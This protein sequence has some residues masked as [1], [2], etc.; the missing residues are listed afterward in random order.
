LSRVS[1]FRD[2]SGFFL[3]FRTG[4]I[5]VDKAVSL[6]TENGLK[7]PTA[8]R[9]VHRLVPRP[10]GIP[11]VEI[12][13]F[14]AATLTV[15]QKVLQAVTPDPGFRRGRVAGVQKFLVFLDSGACPGPD[16]GSAGM[17]EK[18]VF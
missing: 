11:A 7:G 9:T 18:G 10:P 3:F 2:S 1:P 14:H 5:L 15:S 13:K 4:R 12:A 17:T 16:P 8:P 6:F